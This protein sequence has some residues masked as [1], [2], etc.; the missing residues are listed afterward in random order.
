MQPYLM[1]SRTFKYFAMK[2]YWLAC[3]RKSNFGCIRLFLVTAII[4]QLCPLNGKCQSLSN[5]FQMKGSTTIKGNEMV[6][7]T[8][9][10]DLTKKGVQD[11]SKIIDGHFSFKGAISNPAVAFIRLDR[12]KF[13]DNETAIMFIEPAMMEMNLVSNPFEV[14]MISGSKTQ[15][16]YEGLNRSKKNLSSKYKETIDSLKS[17]NGNKAELEIKII[18]YY[19]EFKKLDIDFFT[20]HPHSFATGFLL[21]SY[22]RKLPADALR[23]YYYN[24]DA[25]L[26]QSIYGIRLREL[27]PKIKVVL[28]GK[29]APDF[30]SIS[31]ANEI[32]RLSKF[33][34]RYVLL[35]FWADWCVPCR[36]NFPHLINLYEK[37]HQKGLEIIGVADNDFK[38]EAWKK[39]IENDKVGIWY[40]ILR[41]LQKNEMGV[42]DKTK[43]I[44]DKYNT[45]VLPTKILIDQSGLIVGRYEGTDGDKELEN[46]LRE[47]FE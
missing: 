8:Y 15:L 41:G 33:Q 29:I 27:I 46:K 7:I 12:S 30:T 21:Q 32:I 5:S 18:P 6:Y 44:N 38:Q 24:M 11:S 19:D 35:D 36:E 40:H 13:V 31:Y 26:R 28:P 47:I 1:N 37:Y 25:T 39:A 10:S 23:K 3:L 9:Y 43:S 4:L 34:G 17:G 42:I 22:Y 20:A 16:E 2:Q 14:V 45:H